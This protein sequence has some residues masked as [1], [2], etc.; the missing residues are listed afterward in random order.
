MRAGYAARFFCSK[1][2]DDAYVRAAI[3]K[4]REM[5][6]GS[7][8]LLERHGGVENSK[9]IRAYWSGRRDVYGE[10]D[11]VFARVVERKAY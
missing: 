7:G 6:F 1:S 9:A 2:C 11:V 4:L 3:V 5:S 8:Y 10:G